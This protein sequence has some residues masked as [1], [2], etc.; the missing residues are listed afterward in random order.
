MEISSKAEVDLFKRQILQYE[1]DRGGEEL[2]AFNPSLHKN[3]FE[4]AFLITSRFQSI[5]IL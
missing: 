1:S 5:A 3:S 2:K 4:S